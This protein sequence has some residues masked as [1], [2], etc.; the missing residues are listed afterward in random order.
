MRVTE[1]ASG[2][3]R[4]KVSEGDVAIDATAGRGRDTLLLAT[5]VGASGR[6]HAFDVQPEAIESTRSL[7]KQFG[8]DERCALHLRCHS[9]MTAALPVENR[10]KVAAVVFNLGYLPGS[11]HVVTTSPAT[12]GKALR[13]AMDMLQAGGRLIC[14]CYTGHPG[15]EEESDAVVALARSAEQEGW[16]VSLS[17]HEPGSG[18]PWVACLDRGLV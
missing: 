10:G 17:G 4:E 9:E 1:L 18:R 12:S 13:S 14:V 16:R 7:L 2:L 6:V 5:L 11:D 15:G 3:L 8:V